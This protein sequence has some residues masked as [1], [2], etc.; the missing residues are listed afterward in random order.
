GCG[1]AH[2]LLQL[3][4]AR[5]AQG[6]SAAMMAPVGR[7]LLLRT[8]PKHELVG[9]IAVYTMPAMVGPVIGPVLGGFI[10]T[11]F[12]WRWIFLINLPIAAIGVVLV[13]AFV[14][15]VREREVSP[16]DWVGIALTGVG[17]ASMMFGFENLGRN[18]LPAWQVGLLFAVGAAFLTA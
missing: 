15:D 16:I 9:A 6:A 12:N 18:F 3:I 2:S 1:L 4:V 10:V 13:R 5:V 17:L 7:L 11:Y 8:T 14:P